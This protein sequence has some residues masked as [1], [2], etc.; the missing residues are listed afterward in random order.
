MGARVSLWRGQPSRWTCLMENQKDNNKQHIQTTITKRYRVHGSERPEWRQIHAEVLIWKYVIHRYIFASEIQLV[1]DD[2]WVWVKEVVLL[3]AGIHRTHF[4]GFSL[5]HL[6]IIS[7]GH[8]IDKLWLW[9][10]WNLAKDRLQFESQICWHRVFCDWGPRDS[11]TYLLQFICYDH[12]VWAGWGPGGYWLV[13]CVW[14]GAIRPHADHHQQQHWRPPCMGC[15]RLHTRPLH[16]AICPDCPEAVCQLRVCCTGKWAG[17][18]ISWE[19]RGH[20]SFRQCIYCAPIIMQSNAQIVPWPMPDQVPPTQEQVHICRCL[21]K[22][23][24][25]WRNPFMCACEY[26]CA[27]AG[28]YACACVWAGQPRVAVQ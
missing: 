19:K 5:I 2:N 22:C 28:R 3:L 8:H 1:S 24:C 7:A 26:T 16:C 17:D 23:V 4:L 27:G 25:R 21:S 12:N 14:N 15:T 20:G 11:F 6:A 13:P 18:D 10:V 9:L